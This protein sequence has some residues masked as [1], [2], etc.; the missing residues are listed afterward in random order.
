MDGLDA[1]TNTQVHGELCG[2]LLIEGDVKVKKKETRP[3][4]G[5]RFTGVCVGSGR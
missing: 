5:F 1:K 3:R 2:I 4:I